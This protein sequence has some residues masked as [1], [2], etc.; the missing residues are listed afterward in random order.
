M[1]L[2]WNSSIC[3]GLT[4][5]TP[6]CSEASHTVGVQQVQPPLSAWLLVSSFTVSSEL[7]LMLPEGAH[8]CPDTPRLELLGGRSPENDLSSSFLWSKSPLPSLGAVSEGPSHVAAWGKPAPPQE[9]SS[10]CPQQPSLTASLEHSLG[11]TTSVQ[12]IH[13]V[14]TPG[15]RSEPGQNS[16]F[17]GRAASNW[18][19]QEMKDRR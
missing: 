19:E 5:E 8:R 12:E 2:E 1:L 13:K 17:Q 6:R 10:L 14:S 4:I 16:L 15:R 11:S 3:Q 7:P 9:T 18:R